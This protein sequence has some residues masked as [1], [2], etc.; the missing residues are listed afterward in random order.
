[1]HGGLTLLVVPVETPTEADDQ[2]GELLVTPQQQL[3]L[4][5]HLQLLVVLP[6]GGLFQ[7]TVCRLGLQIVPTSLSLASHSHVCC[8]SHGKPPP[9]QAPLLL[10]IPLVKPTVAD[11]QP[12]ELDGLLHSAPW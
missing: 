3:V 12:G 11:G 5:A 1:M 9:G 7:L 6:P 4:V 2:E 10:L 8:G